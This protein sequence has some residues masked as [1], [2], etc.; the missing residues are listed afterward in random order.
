MR[1]LHFGHAVLGVGLGLVAFGTIGGNSVSATSIPAN[2]T[3]FVRNID[4]TWTV[5]QFL[6]EHGNKCDP[7]NNGWHFILNGLDPSPVDPNNLAATMTI[8]FSDSS[9]STAARTAVNN[10]TAH[11]L[12]S[13]SHQSDGVY[14]LSAYLVFPNNVVTS[15]NNFV[16]SHIPCQFNSTTT[17][18]TT[19]VNST[20]TTAA[21]TTTTMVDSTT[22][23]AA[24]TTTTMV[25]STT[26]TAA[27]TTTT[28][29]E[30]TTTTAAA[31]TTTLP[32][33]TTTTMP[34]TTT[35][36]PAATTTTL[37]GATTT[38]PAVTTTTPA[39]TTTTLAAGGAGTTTTEVR[40]EPPLPTPPPGTNLPVTGDGSS[41]WTMLL[42]GLMILLG[43]I[44]VVRS[45][46]PQNS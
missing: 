18:T 38:A 37:P 34:G 15:Y 16:I 5:E 44:S 24:A 12:N 20:T 2:R 32:G 25:D 29:A 17:T 13:T 26:T 22:T 14:P 42:G 39:A 23:T 30:A 40:S 9:S 27:A 46:R 45:R 35:T 33:A 36:V 11:Y 21:A 1:F 31:T 19:M 10:Q 43:S 28:A 3:I 7:S 6:D 4:A 41:G 8:N